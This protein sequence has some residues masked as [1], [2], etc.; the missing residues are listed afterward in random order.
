MTV[1]VPT[2]FCCV[3]EMGKQCR[4]V[5]SLQCEKLIHSFTSSASL[6]V[7]HPSFLLSLPWHGHGHGHLSTEL[8]VVAKN[9]TW[10]AVYHHWNEFLKACIF[11]LIAAPR[12]RH[13][14]W[15]N[16]LR[17]TKPPKTNTTTGTA[18]PS[19]TRKQRQTRNKRKLLR[20]QIRI[21]TSRNQTLLTPFCYKMF[22]KKLRRAILWTTRTRKR[23]LG[24]ATQVATL[25]VV[26]QNCQTLPGFPVPS[27]KPFRATT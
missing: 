13:C 21:R 15:K 11:A 12:A 4:L 27:W 19:R 16:T 8:T 10:D 17:N 24:E 3:M 6:N 9:F 18:L 14:N 20:V 25:A 2:R 7:L 1:T 22:W 5:K 23:S 26:Q